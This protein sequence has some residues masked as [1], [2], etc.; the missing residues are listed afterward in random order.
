MNEDLMV[1][2]SGHCVNLC[3]HWP[4]AEWEDIANSVFWFRMVTLK[5]SINQDEE[6]SMYWCF[7][8]GNMVGLRNLPKRMFKLF[9]PQLN[10]GVRR[11]PRRKSNLFQH[12]GQSKEPSTCFKKIVKDDLG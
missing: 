2:S 8:I 12:H 6:D 10:V 1:S 11:Q 4:A 9:K 5:S 7:H 3:E